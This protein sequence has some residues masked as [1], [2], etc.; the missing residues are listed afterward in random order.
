MAK[1]IE[2]KRKPV[3]KN[4]KIVCAAMVGYGENIIEG[5]FGLK[6]VASGKKSAPLSTELEVGLSIQASNG[7]NPN[8][9]TEI[10]E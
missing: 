8:K 2:G 7:G 5:Q 3:G 6:D 9:Q 4:K 1:S 10:G